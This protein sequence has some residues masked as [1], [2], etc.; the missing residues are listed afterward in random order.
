MATYQLQV[1]TVN[2]VK[3]FP[4]SPTQT[5]ELEAG[6]NT[7]YQILDENGQLVSDLKTTAV[8][9]DDL[10]IHL[11]QAENPSVVLK[12]YYNYFPIENGA[13]L[14]EISASF[15]TASKEAPFVLASEVT[16]VATSG[17]VS[18]STMALYGAGA[19][20]ATAGIATVA[21]SGGKGGSGEPVKVNEP[22]VETPTVS[23]TPN[24]PAA[25]Q[26]TQPVQPETTVKPQVTAPTA[27]RPTVRPPEPQIE[28][29]P[30]PIKVTL[31]LDNIAQ[32]NILNAQESQSEVEISGTFSADQNFTSA[33]VTLSIGELSVPAQVDGNRF[34]AKVSGA[35]LAENNKVVA[36]ATLKNSR[37][38]GSASKEQEYQIDTQIAEPMITLNPITSDNLLNL[39]ESKTNVVISGKVANVEH[40]A[41]KAGDTVTIQIGDETFTTTLVEK[42]GELHFELAVSG[43]LLAKNSKVSVSVAT[44]DAALNTLN[45]T[46]EQ[47]YEQDLVIADPNIIFDEITADNA[48]NIVE[49]GLAEIVLSGKVENVPNSEAKAGDRVVISVGDTQVETHLIEKNGELRFEKAVSGELLAKNGQ[50]SATL[51]TQ[52]T[53][54]NRAE[55]V[56]SKEYRVDTLIK[57]PQISINEVS[58][59]NIINRQ[60]RSGEPIT[61]SGQVSNDGID[62]AVAK[63]GDKVIIQIG[64]QRFTTELTESL[65]FSLPINAAALA[66]AE[67]ENTLTVSLATKDDVDNALTTVKTHT[68]TLDTVIEDP[69]LVINSVGERNLL[70]SAAIQGDI[71][72]SGF[73]RN[74]NANQAAKAGDTVVLQIG[75]FSKEVT[76]DDALTFS[77][78]IAGEKFRNHTRIDATLKTEDPAGNTKETQAAR[79][80]EVDEIIHHPHIEFSAITSDNTINASE[81]NGT[82]KVLVQGVVRNEE[83]AAAKAN[84]TIHLEIHGQN[85]D[86][87]LVA[88]ADANTFTFSVEVDGSV[89]AADADRLIKATLDTTDRANNTLTTKVEHSYLVDTVIAAPTIRIDSVTADNTVNIAE[90]DGGDLIIR[91]QV[92][93]PTNAEAKAGNKVI[94]TVGQT[95]VEATLDSNLSF[96]AAVS[97]EI[98]AQNSKIVA[99]LTTQ[100][101]AENSNTTT[102]EHEY[103]VDTLIAAPTLTI[104]KIATDDIINAVEKREE[105]IL[106]SGS[107][108]NGEHAEAKPND[109][110]ELRIGELVVPARLSEQLTFEVPVST[111]ALVNHKTI[112][113]TLVTQDRAENRITATAEKT[114]TVDDTLALS[115]AITQVDQD[116]LINIAD[117]TKQI[118]LNGT[119]TADNDVKADSIRISVM[120]KGVEH[121]ATVD[122]QNNSWTLSVTGSE[123]VNEQGENTITAKISAEDQSGNAG[124][125]TQPYNYQV[126]T[127]IDKPVVTITS[128]AEDDVIDVEEAKGEIT[129]RGFVEHYEGN[130][131]VTLLC[132]CAA[133]NSGWKEVEAQVVDGKFEVAVLVS[134][135]SLADAKL[136]SEERKIKAKYTARDE[137][138]NEA[139]ADEASRLYRLDDSREVNIT[140]IDD[141]FTLALPQGMSRIYGSIEEFSTINKIAAHGVYNQGMNA[142]FIRA[143]NVT[144][145]EKTYQV[146]FDGKAKSFYIDIPNSDL[147][148]LSGKSVALDFDV[149][150]PRLG[151]GDLQQSYLNRI[152]PKVLTENNGQKSVSALNGGYR[153]PIIPKAVKFTLESDL[154]EGDAERG[155]TVKTLETAKSEISGVVRG[156]AEGAEI[157]VTI[158]THKETAIVTADKTFKVEVD[159]ALLQNNANQIVTAALKTDAAVRDVENYSISQTVGENYVSTH[160]E[161]PREAR[162]ID[163]NSDNYNFFYPIALAELFPARTQGFMKSIPVGVTGSPVTIKYH[164]ATD[165]ELAQMPAKTQGFEISTEG[166]IRAVTAEVKEWFKSVYAHISQSTNIRFEETATWEEV[167]GDKG[168]L[169]FATDFKPTSYA[170]TSP[171]IGFAG[172]NVLWSN[173]N[174]LNNKDEKFNLALHE[175]LHTLNLEHTHTRFM[176]PKGPGY[177][178]SYNYEGEETVEFSNLS[179]YRTNTMLGIRGL[180]IFDLM[181][182][183]YRYGVNAAHRSG[184]DVYTF[185]KYDGLK[186]DGDIYVWDGAGVDTF[187]A[188]NEKAGVT[189][190]LTPGSWNYVGEKQQNF[191][192][193]ANGRVTIQEF[194]GLPNSESI[195]GNMWNYGDYVYDNPKTNLNKIELVNYVEGQSFIGY[196]TQIENL[197]GSKFDDKLTGNNADNNIFG[198][199]GDDIIVGGLGNDFINGGE[200]NDLM[201]GGEGNDIYVVDS[202][203]DIV[204]EEA[205][206]G[207]DHVYSL[208]DHTLENNVENLTLIGT[209][210]KNA[211]GNE[212]GN[213]I[214]GNDSGNT[215]NGMAGDDTLIGGLGKDTLTGGE[216]RDTFVFDSALNGKTDT[217]TDFVR[218]ED[219]IQL[220]KA[221]FSAINDDLSNLSQHLFYDAAS[222]T[223]SYNGGNSGETDAVSFVTV[224]GLGS[225]DNNVFILA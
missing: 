168:T 162:I 183:H 69:T 117:T 79:D 124:E 197:I 149:K 170:K 38:S 17:A 195:S 66:A 119:Y 109:I 163:H 22:A 192:A 160:Q 51:F 185:K 140:K 85:F 47:A 143:L 218:G 76:L 73:A 145:G 155:Y 116:D 217:I 67:G 154:L 8:G 121:Q 48:I 186:I 12:D 30:A 70:N 208:V 82:D 199:A 180:K 161:V 165:E 83:G 128:I 219:K 3:T 31:N 106:V 190:N 27:T 24:T 179:Y 37:S 118:T 132:P 189:V 139:E 65:S 2:G 171:A 97:G 68:Y 55:T 200:G 75:T 99:K 4:L 57:D 216:G 123:L 90:R 115:V 91:G 5:I 64:E 136:K 86:G 213:I 58:D 52:D 78:T 98:L 129:I 127:V 144:I 18:F 153:A 201:F 26:P 112:T 209:A 42:E 81:A 46:T 175:V 181:Y 159:R 25:V 9:Q 10:A 134:E 50:I 15:A 43:D 34:S 88:G 174:N 126:D 41:A 20:A 158:G 113:A 188:S 71:T 212:L 205:D 21:R 59:K 36:Q 96:S 221:V 13:Y 214:R 49:S 102:Y 89:L 210:A 84:D 191:V 204:T 94:L 148:A 108:A 103:Q 39:S 1:T 105:T 133:C 167:D 19:L 146:G 157:E 138:G 11:G 87:K 100:D 23:V 72:V 150:I 44:T 131:P 177:N 56:K 29:P 164:F 142:R 184:N 107:A 207:T 53:A 182:L 125:A 151:E 95:E 35:V 156:I 7:K 33:Q 92:E 147:P 220:S 28:T 14:N 60:E 187:D 173:K 16:G 135:T 169:I 45:S 93:N 111:I 77:T 101:K 80:Y 130:G 74:D 224:S 114:I 211:T 141:A 223:L 196:G 61:V 40:S 32:D 166:T 122:T 193:T 206:K 225:I 194:F 110:V 63:Q 120:L 178:I 172:G 222:G 176:N 137:A 6:E 198:G 202:A 62:G 104:N 203:A 54:E 152:T 215:I